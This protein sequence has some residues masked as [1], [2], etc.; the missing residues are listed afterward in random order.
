MPEPLRIFLSHNKSDKPFVRSF[1]ADLV[2]AGAEVWFD[3]WELHPGDSI[4]TAIDAG[5]ATFDSFTLVWSENALQSK[6]VRAERDAALTRW[7]ADDSYKLIPI[8]LD[9]TPLPPLLSPIYHIDATDGNHQRVARE[10]LGLKTQAEFLQAVQEFIDNSGL[11]FRWF[12]EAGVYVCCPKC[13]AASSELEAWEET[14]PRR[15][16]LYRGVR[17]KMCGWNEGGE[18]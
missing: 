8:R 18:V 10:L 15:G 14:D 17:C 4:P 1:A 7:L 9:E 13:C 12:S 16:D 11:D 3:E 5:L 6:W 2:L